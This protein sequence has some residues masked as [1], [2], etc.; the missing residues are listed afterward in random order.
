MASNKFEDEV[1]R[2]FTGIDDSL[3]Y[4][5]KWPCP[6]FLEKGLISPGLHHSGW[7][8][9]FFKG[10]GIQWTHSGRV[11]EKLV[12]IGFQTFDFLARPE[13]FEP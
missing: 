5:A 6:D 9:Y 2:A 8:S 13:G 4:Q 7:K 11:G 10:D 1:Y 12:Y 3:V